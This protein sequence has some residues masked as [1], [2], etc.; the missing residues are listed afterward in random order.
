DHVH[1]LEQSISSVLD[2]D[3]D[4]VAS[5]TSVASLFEYLKKI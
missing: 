3:R 2:D 5:N 1:T 4:E